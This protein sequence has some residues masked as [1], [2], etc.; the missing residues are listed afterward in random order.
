MDFIFNSSSSKHK[1]ALT[2]YEPVLKTRKLHKRGFSITSPTSSETNLTPK[3]KFLNFP[4]KKSKK[5]DFLEVVDQSLNYF[6]DSQQGWAF[7]DDLLKA[8]IRNLELDKE[9]LKVE[10]SKLQLALAQAKAKG[11]VY[12]AKVKSLKS[13]CKIL[14]TDSLSQ[15]SKEIFAGNK[16]VAGKIREKLLDDSLVIHNKSSDTEFECTNRIFNINKK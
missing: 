6:L 15:L 10:N 5:G 14:E 9:K 8:R 16:E 7:E 4:V 2:E 11:T 12:K 3:V 1:K 13:Y